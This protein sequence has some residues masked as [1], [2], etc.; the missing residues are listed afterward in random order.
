MDLSLLQERLAAAERTFEILEQ[1]LAD[2]AVASNP[3]QLQSLAR[4]RSRLEPLVVDQRQ[5]EPSTLEEIG[6][7]RDPAVGP[8]AWKDP[9]GV[10]V[11]S[12]EF[13][14][15][16]PTGPSPYCRT[17]HNVRSLL[18]QQTGHRGTDRLLPSQHRPPR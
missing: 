2:P 4:E 8:P 1:Q 15:N 16:P 10:A 11:E 12:A 7:F 17:I 18:V 3:A 5:P 6:G 14:N 9:R 13:V